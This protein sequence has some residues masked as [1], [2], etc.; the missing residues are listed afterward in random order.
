MDPNH[1]L[2]SYVPG[3]RG[4][5]ALPPLALRSVTA[6]DGST[7]YA[8]SDTLFK[9]AIFGRDSLDVAEDLM[10]LRPNLA[11][12]ILLTLGR[13]Q[14]LT[15]NELNEE[16]PGKIIHEYRTVIVDK[17]PITDSQMRIFRE[18]AAKWGGSDQELTYYGSIDA[19]PHFLRA[20]GMYSQTHGS[21]ILDRQL[22]Q[23]N[24]E[25]TTMRQ[26]AERAAAWLS[27][28]LSTSRSG[29]IE[30]QRMN[31]EGLPNQVWK[32]S[33]E[34]YIHEDKSLANH[35]A[36]IASIEVQALGYDALMAAASFFPD[37]QAEFRE[38]AQRL[39]DRTFDLLWQEDRHYFALGLDYDEAGS[40]RLIRTKTANPAALLDSGFFEELPGAEQER[41]VTA[42]ASTILSPDFLTDAGIRSRALSAAHLVDSSD[43]HG[44]HVSWP[45]E[46]YDIAKGLRRQGMPLLARQ[47]ENRLLNLVL[48]TR[49]YPE[50]VY[51]DEWG[52]VLAGRPSTRQHS[53]LITVAGHNTPERLQAWTVSAIMAIMGQRL[54]EKGRKKLKPDQQLWQAELE[55]TLMAR[56]PH[57]NRYF[58]PLKLAA[59]YPA[60][61]YRLTENNHS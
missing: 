6:K 5:L 60:H 2:F 20:L 59:R 31:P 61:R 24:G 47:L 42:L 28:R 27:G 37:K 19:T 10:T 38:A 26:V 35:D 25:T 3:A 8:S 7:V 54:G 43:Y 21:D 36:P 58:N 13:L 48:R 9:G 29:L 11:R 34:F 50:F 30:Y 55:A 57:V 14:G 18:L 40:L 33:T 23:R 53:N 39:R 17:R 46:T 16:E 52:R 56:I 12:N 41:Y 22:I 1:P 49:E 44:S 15:T 4:A 51:V 32:D 45:K